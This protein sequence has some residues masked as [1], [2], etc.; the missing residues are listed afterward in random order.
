MTTKMDDMMRDIDGVISSLNHARADIEYASMCLR[1]FNEIRN[2]II[3]SIICTTC[4][5][6]KRE[7]YQINLNSDLDRVTWDAIMHLLAINLDYGD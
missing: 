3:D 5:G 1:R 7:T 6:D 4:E 2:I